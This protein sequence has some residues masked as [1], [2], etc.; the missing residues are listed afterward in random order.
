MK[1]L[2]LSIQ[3]VVVL[4]TLISVSVAQQLAERLEDLSEKHGFTYEALVTDT[5]F[6]EK[7]AVYI[8]QPLDHSKPDGAQFKQ[9][10][11]ISH[12][13]FKAPSVFITEG[14]GAQYGKHPSYINE[15]TDI[16]DANQ[17]CVEHRFF[18]ESVPKPLDWE[19]LTVYNAASDHHRIVSLMKLIY[20]E[21][22]VNTG[23]SK[24]G[25]TAIYH[26]YFYPND[27]DV[28]V[29]YVCPLNFSSEDPR[30]Y[31]FLERVGDE[32]CRQSIMDMQKDFLSNKKL[33]LPLFDSICDQRQLV[34]SMGVEKAFEL[35]VLELSFAFW[36]WSGDC[37]TVPEDSSNTLDRLL[38]L[39][40][41][42][43]FDW[44]SETGIAKFEPFFYQAMRE[45]GFYGYDISAFRPWISYDD[46]PTFEFTLPE[47]V[48]VTF[49][50]ELMQ[51]VDYFVRHEAEQMIY[52]YGEI[53]PWS[54]TAVE[55]T[56][57]KRSL[58]IVKPGGNHATRI[59]NLP[60]DQQDQVL[61]SLKLWLEIND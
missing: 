60:K 26:R 47:G 48:E 31:R 32:D 53:D 14:Y 39:D 43:G 3:I 36:Q 25:Q 40:K 45:I 37:S 11:F 2:R 21:K 51:K 7:Y 18:G 34:F 29:G 58:K 6:T 57:Q 17:I 19:Q 5:F 10:F 41:V 56:Y 38:Y 12:K 30:V 44:I 8:D 61:S 52:I 33:Y 13:G 23:I 20:K 59:S 24:G 28:T 16:L 9:R 1:I 55:P 35:T 42:A 49:E 4:F 50:P 22:F 15:L 46:N 27:V 54:S